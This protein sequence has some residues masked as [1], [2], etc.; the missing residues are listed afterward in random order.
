MRL[1]LIED[2]RRL[3]ENIKGGLVESGFAVDLAFDGEEG[4]HLAE[5]ES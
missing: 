1:L 5:T 4:Q 2:Q 3:A